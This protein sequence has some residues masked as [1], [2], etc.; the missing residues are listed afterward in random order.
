VFLAGHEV[1]KNLNTDIRGSNPAKDMHVR[2][3]LPAE[4]MGLTC[5]CD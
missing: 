2:P 5:S 1:L 4:A 3:H